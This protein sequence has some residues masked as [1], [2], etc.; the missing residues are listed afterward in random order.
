MF[1]FSSWHTYD[2]DG[3][4]V[5]TGNRWHTPIG[6]GDILGCLFGLIILLGCMFFFGYTLQES[7]TVSKSVETVNEYYQVVG[8]EK[9]E[10]EDS[11]TNEYLY[12]EY[13]Y[14][15][16]FDVDGVKRRILV[17]ES[18]FNTYGIGKKLLLQIEKSGDE[19]T[20]VK[21]K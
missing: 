6:T 15:L 21:L 16:Y 10:V 20:S 7:I 5:F 8:K 17:S 9:I 18:I 3:N 1:H 4:I 2:D 12:G 19:V 14:V 13:K 11:I